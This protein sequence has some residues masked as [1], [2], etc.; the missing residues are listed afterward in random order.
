ME[1]SKERLRKFRAK[2]VDSLLGDQAVE[3]AKFSLLLELFN[4]DR[5]ELAKILELC[6]HCEKVVYKNGKTFRKSCANIP[7]MK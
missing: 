6:K 1:Y 4:T 7:K 3:T 5:F 2:M